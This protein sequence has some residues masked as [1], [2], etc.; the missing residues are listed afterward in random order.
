MRSRSFV[1]RHLVR[2]DAAGL[3]A[4][5]RSSC[6]ER[7]RGRQSAAAFRDR[8]CDRV[9]RDHAVA[10]LRAPLAR[11]IFTTSRPKTSA[12][13]GDRF[14]PL[15]TILVPA[16]NEERGHSR[17]D[18]QPARARLSGVRHSGDRRRLDRRHLCAGRGVRGLLWPR[19]RS[20][21]Q[22]EQRRQGAALNTG[23]ALARTP[24]VLCMDGDSRLAPGTLRYAM[25]HFRDPRVGAV[26]GN[27]KV[28]NRRNLWTCLQALEYIEGLNMARRA[29]GFV[30][31]VNIVPG[32]IGIFRAIRWRASAATTRHLR[33]GRRPDA[34]AVDRRLAHRLRG[35]RHRVHRGA[36]AV[37]S[38]SSSSATAGRA[39]F[40]R[41][42]RSIR[43]RSSRRGSVSRRG[44]RCS[45]CCSRR[46][47]GR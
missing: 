27:V 37:C 21:R 18:P 38:T 23:I 32:P 46:S 12:D 28:V 26:A 8:R 43:R 44:S 11:R 9:P 7:T 35:S 41:R 19:D 47:R 5:R 22:Q 29:Q 13:D 39:E 30:R 42:S 20:R 24:F 31:A 1:F 4:L 16:Y 25:P 6:R 15:V 33:R 34:Q 45:R 10:L 36:R 3:G 40:S 14:E 2:R 17:R